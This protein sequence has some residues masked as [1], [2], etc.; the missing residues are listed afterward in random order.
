MAETF[1]GGHAVI[2]TISSNTLPS[3]SVGSAFVN[4]AGLNCSVT[5]W[6]L[7]L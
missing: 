1:F 4:T 6:T 5:S 3:A 7:A 2:T